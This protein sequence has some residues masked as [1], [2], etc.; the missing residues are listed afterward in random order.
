MLN[1]QN[2]FTNLFF[3]DWSFIQ[4][5]KIFWMENIWKFLLRHTVVSKSDGTWTTLPVNIIGKYTQRG[6]RYDIITPCRKYACL[7]G[8]RTNIYRVWRPTVK[9]LT[10]RDPWTYSRGM[11]AVKHCLIK[12]C[13]AVR[14][15]TDRVGLILTV[16]SHL[17]VVTK[18]EP[19]LSSGLIEESRTPVRL[20]NYIYLRRFAI[21]CSNTWDKMSCSLI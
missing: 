3:V 14:L 15:S 8:E 11:H 21:D 12:T 20:H 18:Q 16:N 19:L 7:T 4:V 10:W 17:W 9:I 2:L 1:I 6:A 13:S 5:W